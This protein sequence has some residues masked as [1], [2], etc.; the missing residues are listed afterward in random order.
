M[1]NPD[2]DIL[3]PKDNARQGKLEFEADFRLLLMY[4]T[5]ASYAAE[6]EDSVFALIDNMGIVD[7]T[8]I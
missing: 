5:E 4:D 1:I 6:G 8:R 2:R 3:Q 7:F